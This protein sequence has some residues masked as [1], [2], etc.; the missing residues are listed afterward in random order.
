M[1]FKKHI[2]LSLAFFLLVS[3]VGFAL[4]VHYCRGKV[5]SVRPVYWKNIESPEAVKDNCCGSNAAVLVEKKDSC[6][7]D[8][9]VHFQK[10]SENVTLNSSFFQPDF[11]FLFEEWS[12][13]VYSEISNIEF[14]RITSY[15]CDANAPPLFKLYHQYIFY[16]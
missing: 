10:K 7:K 11:N 16:A 15:Y 14:N 4:D 12:P 9:M 8:K 1:R 6:C 5:A 3:N 13:I 2:S